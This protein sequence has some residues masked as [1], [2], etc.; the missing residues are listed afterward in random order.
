MKDARVV[1]ASGVFDLLHAGHVAFLREAK[2]I[3]GEEGRLV[4]VVAS[5]RVVRNRK[6]RSPVLPQDQRIMIVKAIRYVDEVIAG[7]PDLDIC[8]I[9][10]RVRPDIVV[11][12]Y[13][14]TWLRKLVEEAAREARLSISIVQLPRFPVKPGSSTEVRRRLLEKS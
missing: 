4:V 12:G 1:L 9:L 7:T 5:D 8:D 6:G 10:R 2:R 3:A 13:D 11:L 14:Q